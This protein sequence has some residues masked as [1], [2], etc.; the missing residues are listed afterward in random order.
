MKKKSLFIAGTFAT[1]VGYFGSYLVWKRRLMASLQAGSRIVE[2][3]MGP[4]EYCMRG[5]GPAVLVAH[6][7]PG[8]Y[9]Q[10]LAFSK[11]VGGQQTF[12]AV[13]RPGYLR[14]PLTTG[15]TSAVQAD[16]Y[17]ALLDSL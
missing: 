12:I 7:S 15:E 14:T 4:V 9:D 13:S 3:A 8:G 1:V 11:L 6:G 17:A 2:T 16:M 5:Q 10:G